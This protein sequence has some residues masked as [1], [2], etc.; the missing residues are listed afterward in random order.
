MQQ[1]G[2]SGAAGVDT[3]RVTGCRALRFGSFGERW[4]DVQRLAASDRAGTLKHRGNWTL[5]QALGHLATWG[6]FAFDGT[7][8]RPPWFIK[9]ILRMRKNRYL[10]EG[11]PRG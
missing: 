11:M 8:L 9:L 6:Q 7:P 10:N 2:N 3:G 1:A 5:G 4:S